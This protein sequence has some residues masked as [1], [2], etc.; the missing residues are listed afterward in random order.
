M[1]PFHRSLESSEKQ[2]AEVKVDWDRCANDRTQ[3]LEEFS[4]LLQDFA[5]HFESMEHLRAEVGPL[6][7]SSRLFFT[8]PQVHVNVR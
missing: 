3:A 2:L 8:P 1:K 7:R 5:V 4:L 6:T